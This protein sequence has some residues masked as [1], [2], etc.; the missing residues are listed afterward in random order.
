MIERQ[1]RTAGSQD[2]LEQALPPSCFPGRYPRE[3]IRALK[4]IDRDLE[5]RW[6][7]RFGCWEVWH[8]R[9]DGLEYIFYRHKNEWGQ[10]R[11]ADTGLVTAVMARA[12]WTPHG[13][14]VMSRLRM[15]GDC[16]PPE[17]D[18]ERLAWRAMKR[19]GG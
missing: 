14:G 5:L 16:M 2:A 19:K 13:R 9:S 1:E 8:K 7:K 12:M 10:Y 11:E 17:K 6:S 3:V 18:L 15:G 4:R